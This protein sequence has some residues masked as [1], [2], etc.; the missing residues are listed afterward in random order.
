VLY[1][2]AIRGQQIVGRNGILQG[3]AG[4][5]VPLEGEIAGTNGVQQVGTGPSGAAV[6]TGT[7]ASEVNLNAFL[8]TGILGSYAESI[9]DNGDVF[10]QGRGNGIN[11]PLEWI[12]H[13][14]PGDAN[15]DGS[16]TF[17]DLVTLAQHFGQSGGY[18]YGD[19]NLDGQVDFADLLVLAQNYGQTLTPAQMARLDPAFAAD[20]QSA[21]SHVPE[22]GLGIMLVIGCAMLVRRRRP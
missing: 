4:T 8:P 14:V 18:I 13:R 16:V 6:W 17:D 7:Q 2:V 19:F 11:H 3:P 20:V 1:P 10:G 12:P 22:P 21:F 15:F 5:F 9:D